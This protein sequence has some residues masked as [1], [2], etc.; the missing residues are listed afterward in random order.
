MPASLVAKPVDLVTE[1]ANLDAV[2]SSLPVFVA[3]HQQVYCVK[4]SYPL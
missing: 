3:H 4:V 2:P 1:P